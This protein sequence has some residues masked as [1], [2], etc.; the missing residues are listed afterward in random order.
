MDNKPCLVIG[1][2]TIDVFMTPRVSDT[3]CRMDEENPYICF[4]YGDKIPVDALEFTTGGNAANVCVGLE[5]MGMSAQLCTTIGDDGV[6]RMIIEKLHEERVDLTH[7]TKQIHGTT[8]Y[9]TIISYRGER[10]IFAYHAP[11]VYTF[12]EPFPDVSFIYLTSMGEHFE[13]FV[14]TLVGYLHTH[15][16]IPLFFNPGSIQLRAGDDA[17]HMILQATQFL[18]V[19]RKEAELFTHTQESEGKEMDILKKLHALGPKKIIMTDGNKGAYGS[20]GTI[21]Y[22]SNVIPTTVVEKTGAGDSFN[23]GFIAAY[24][25]NQPF[26][27]AM[28]WGAVNSSS[29]IGHVGAQRGLLHKKDMESWLSLAKKSG[30]KVTKEPI[31][32]IG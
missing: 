22:S 3:L 18:F 25:D 6:S 4:S 10:T 23:V 12:P 28:Q 9:S 27:I 17:I 30:L 16:D 24:M 1:D 2:P 29:V 7:I 20:D 31:V 11:R 19:N 32:K 5:R 8:N 13:S 26:D 21:F 15:A 14:S